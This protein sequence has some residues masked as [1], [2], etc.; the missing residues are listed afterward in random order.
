MPPAPTGP[1]AGAAPILSFNSLTMRWASLGPTPL[2]RAIIALSP[3]ATARWSSSGSS[4]DNIASATRDPTPCTWVS[5]RYQSRS[6][7][8]AKPTRRIES[9]ATSISVWIVTASPIVPNAASVR[10]EAPTR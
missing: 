2:A 10:E 5:S 6:S 8:R 3:M 7:A 1:P 9:A 4:A